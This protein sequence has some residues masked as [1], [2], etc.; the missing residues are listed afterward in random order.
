MENFH[1]IVFFFFEGFPNIDI[2]LFHYRMERKVNSKPN[3]R[4]GQTKFTRL[5]PNVANSCY[6]ILINT[7]N[8]SVLLVQHQKDITHPYVMIPIGLLLI[9]LGNTWTPITALDHVKTQDMDVRPVVIMN[10][11]NA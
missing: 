9:T 2:Q 6:S 8:R 5:A 1:T 10:I 7:K 11:S 3:V 4:I